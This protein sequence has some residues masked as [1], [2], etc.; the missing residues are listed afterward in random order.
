MEPCPSI[1]SVTASS[2]YP[3]D[4]GFPRITSEWDAEEFMAL[5]S[6]MTNGSVIDEDVKSGEFMCQS[7]N[8]GFAGGEDAYFNG[9]S[10]DELQAALETDVS[11]FSASGELDDNNIA[12][13]QNITPSRSPISC[14]TESPSSICGNQAR[15]ASS[16]EQSDEDDETGPCEQIIDPTD[17][18]DRR[19]K[20]NRESARR[21]RRRKQA[22]MADLET[23]VEQLRVENSNLSKQLIDADQHFREANTDN[24]V[25][26]SG[27]EA[28]RAKV[29]LAEDIVARGSLTTLN[30]Q[31]LQTPSQHLNPHNN[32]RRSAAHVSPSIPVQ[33]ND[34]SSYTASMTVGAQ[35]PGLSL[36]NLNITTNSFNPWNLK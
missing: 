18:R 5:V 35:N 12:W 10:L 7:V 1:Q 25:L 23:Q 20:S 30:N 32:L 13:A 3:A 29:K 11:E 4:G 6:E 34:A 15:G 36:E 19:K 31:L 22:H 16:G 33:G 21:S 27:V 17:K 2:I 9:V 24:R 28:L 26:K 14:I 8:R